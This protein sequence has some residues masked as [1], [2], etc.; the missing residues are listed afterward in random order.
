MKNKYIKRDNATITKREKVLNDKK[1]FNFVEEYTIKDLTITN[2][3]LS[4]VNNEKLNSTELYEIT[5][6]NLIPKQQYKINLEMHNG[7]K[8]GFFII[9]FNKVYKLKNSNEIKDNFPHDLILQVGYQINQKVQFFLDFISL[10]ISD[11][12]QLENYEYLPYFHKRITISEDG[13]L[14]NSNHV[15]INVFYDLSYHIKD[16][17][18]YIE[19]DET[20]IQGFMSLITSNHIE[21][22]QIYFKNQIPIYKEIILEG[23]L[24]TTYLLNYSKQNFE[25]TQFKFNANVIFFEQNKND[26]VENIY[27]FI[28]KY[29]EDL[30]SFFQKDIYND[31][32][33]IDIIK[34][35]FICLKDINNKLNYTLNEKSSIESLYLFN[36]SFI[37]LFNLVSIKLKAEKCGFVSIY[38]SIIYNMNMK[39]VTDYDF[40][41]LLFQNARINQ[42]PYFCKINTLSSENQI[43][44]DEQF[45]KFINNK[46]ENLHI[47]ERTKIINMYCKNIPQINIELNLYYKQII[48]IL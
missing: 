8:I 19:Y 1:H 39:A 10:N 28:E 11:E 31:T 32:F 13:L 9:K 16:S 7:H 15:D 5:I 24:R 23:N 21:D 42:N 4:N 27:F 22:F 35:K 44:E 48:I 41:N 36:I 34:F 47:F 30:F 37:S 18:I 45:I 12:S 33:I 29:S 26:I 20:L 43:I 38:D 17:E 14:F 6:K 25:Y 3:D 40:H 46:I 2:F